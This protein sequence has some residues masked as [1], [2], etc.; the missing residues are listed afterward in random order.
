MYILK[1]IVSSKCP[2]N[3][4]SNFIMSRMSLF[5]KSHCLSSVTIH[6]PRDGDSAGAGRGGPLHGRAR[7]R[8]QV[9]P[10]R[11]VGSA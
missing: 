3:Q 9:V 10:G 8:L 7:A 1:R 11:H 6:C 5:P 2:E 4:Y